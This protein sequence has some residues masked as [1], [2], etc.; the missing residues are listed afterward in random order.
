MDTTEKF[1]YL[2]TIGRISGSPRRIEIWFVSSDGKFYVLAETF[3]RAQWVMNIQNNPNVRFSIGGARESQ[4][5]EF[6]GHARVLDQIRD[7]GLWQKV[8]QLSR[9][10]YGWG[11]GLPV[12][13]CIVNNGR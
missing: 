5:H 9:D 1:L 10:K 11:D 7:A 3:H 6:Q 12:E 8:Q 4:G 13:L 2:A